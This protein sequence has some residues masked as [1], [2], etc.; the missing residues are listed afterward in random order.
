MVKSVAI[1]GANGFLGKYLVAAFHQ[2]GYSVVAVYNKSLTSIGLD[3]VSWI[4]WTDFLKG[5][6]TV[7]TIV[8]S[9]S[10][11]PYGTMN[12]KNDEMLKVNAMQVDDIYQL[13][14]HVH[15]IYISSVSIYASSQNP[16]LEN[17]PWRPQNA[18]A[19]TKLAGELLSKKFERNAILRC[20]SIYG[21]GMKSNTF[22][23]RCIDQAKK[24]GVIVLYGDG[25]RRQNYI[26]ALDVANMCALIP[27]GAEIGEYLAVASESLDNLSIATAI[28][29]GLSAQVQF[30]GEDE[31]PSFY[32]DARITYQKLNYTP[33][34][35][36]LTTIKEMCH[37]E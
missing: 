36:C 10:I 12:E 1:V 15:F 31:S 33:E 7:D 34:K 37:A 2:K 18:Y 16:I 13:Y 14:P 20:S 25:S 4:S 11:I 21:E 23:P 35:N 5:D 32:Y 9:A 8:Y 30:T 3:Q 22:I 26:H 6:C 29:E 24:S 17:S 19:E 27:D 28:G